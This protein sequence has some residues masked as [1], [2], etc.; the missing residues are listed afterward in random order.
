MVTV[1]ASPPCLRVEMGLEKARVGSA[2]AWEGESLISSYLRLGLSKMPLGPEAS[3]HC[4]QAQMQLCQQRLSRVSSDLGDFPPKAYVSGPFP[5]SFSNEP[6]SG[7]P[8][9]PMWSDSEGPKS[10]CPQ[11]PVGGCRL[12]PWGYRSTMW[13]LE[14]TRNPFGGLSQSGRS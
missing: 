14:E 10:G 2:E 6:S 9:I 5:L 8:H 4:H 11:T 12:C 13:L 1:E 3:E 7:S